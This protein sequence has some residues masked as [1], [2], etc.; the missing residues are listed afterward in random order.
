MICSP[1]SLVTS[2]AASVPGNDTPSSFRPASTSGFV[3]I[4]R[5]LTR[6]EMIGGG[7]RNHQACKYFDF[8]DAM[9]AML[10]DLGAS[11]VGFFHE[12]TPRA[13]G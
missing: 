6:L 1:A 13:A 4:G 11:H 5:R 3:G 12:A 2:P 8:E 9:N 10:R 7:T